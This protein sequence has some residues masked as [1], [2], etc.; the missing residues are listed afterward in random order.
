MDLAR[1]RCVLTAVAHLHASFWPEPE[2]SAAAGT[3]SE[4]QQQQ[5]ERHP[6]VESDGGKLYSQETRPGRGGAGGESGGR[7]AG[8]LHEQGTFWSLEK[9]DPGD[10]AG[11]EQTYERLLESFRPLLPEEWFSDASNPPSL[12]DAD[13]GSGTA[14]K[15][16]SDIADGNGEEVSGAGSGGGGDAAARRDHSSQHR[17]TG[18]GRERCLGNRLAARAVEL[19][20]AVHAPPPR[21][22]S[23][24][25]PGEGDAGLAT[26][27]GSSRGRRGRSLVHGDLKT[28]NVFFS[29]GVWGEAGQ[30]GTAGG[31]ATTTARGKVK[32]IDWQVCLFRLGDVGGAIFVLHHLACAIRSRPFARLQVGLSPRSINLVFHMAWAHPCFGFTISLA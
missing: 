24:S 23:L 13:G 28:W 29:A 3:E 26:G 27:V 22:W 20:A 5:P 16:V 12:A 11:L 6:D 9:R 1:A 25:S 18:L 32:I 7:Y 2:A 15:T 17:K 4:R 19:D 21:E 10:L 8:G 31:A 30:D 14:S